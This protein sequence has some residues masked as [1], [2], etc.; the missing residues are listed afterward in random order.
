MTEPSA[1]TK[2]LE[3]RITWLALKRLW[4][5]LSGIQFIRVGLS[6]ALTEIRG[7]PFREL[8]PPESTKE[9]LSRR[10]IGPAIAL[11]QALCKLMPRTNALEL[12]GAIVKEST[13]LFLERA[14]GPL[15]RQKIM[16]QSETERTNWVHRVSAQFFNATMDFKEISDRAVGFHVNRCLFP[17]L[18]KR[19]NV[20]EL[21]PIFCEGDAH[22]FGTEIKEVK[23]T[24]P[25][26][27]ARGD[28][29]CDFDLS[30]KD[31]NS[32]SSGL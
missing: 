4:Q 19:V 3:A 10:Q 26:T 11:Y 21:A 2:T 31:D 22:Y 9:V 18:C 16:E 29:H 12:C 14:I 1:L 32:D 25:L 20:P 13:P 24:R 5:S 30:W 17:E 28:S 27:I 15:N 6:L 7:G 23:L 8:P